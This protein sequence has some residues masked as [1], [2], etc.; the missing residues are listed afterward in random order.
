M[1]NKIPKQ[2]RRHFMLWV[3]VSFPISFI[4]G[5]TFGIV[6]LHLIG[7]KMSIGRIVFCLG[8]ALLIGIASTSS[9]YRRLINRN[10]C[11]TNKSSLHCK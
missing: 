5:G 10:S 4:L 8:I 11:G 6:M 7:I 3:F 9:Y 1:F 2:D